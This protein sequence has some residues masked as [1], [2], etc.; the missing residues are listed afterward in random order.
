MIE[1][2]GFKTNHEKREH[3]A[4]IDRDHAQFFL[5]NKELLWK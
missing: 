3:G 2:T 1:F 4:G 5:K